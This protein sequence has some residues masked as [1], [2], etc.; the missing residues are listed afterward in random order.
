MNSVGYDK[1]FELTAHDFAQ[2]KELVYKHAGIHLPDVKITLVK[3]RLRKR[4]L[5][6]N[7]PSYRQYHKYLCEPGHIGEVQK[8][9]NEI[10]TNETFFFRHKNHWDFFMSTFLDTWRVSHKKNDPIRIWCAASSTGEEPYSTAIALR[11]AFPD[12][13]ANQLVIDASDLNEDVLNLARRGVYCDYATQKMTD[14][15][16]KKYL[17]HDTINNQY[18]VK[19]E[20]KKLVH[21]SH[22]NLMHEKRG[23]KYDLIFIRNVLIYFDNSSKDVVLNHL[24][25]VLKPGGYMIFGGA[26]TLSSLQDEFD[27]IQPTIYRKK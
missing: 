26:E 27:Y 3:N 8:C 7:L 19:D 5:A 18:K 9:L 25:N 4:L 1:Q 2:F 6:L 24:Y 20:V 11:E 17:L 16:K 22:H 10:T 21:Y 12:K 13:P 23:S 15:C 14:H